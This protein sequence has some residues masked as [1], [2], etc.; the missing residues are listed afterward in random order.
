M[1]WV[2]TISV[3]TAIT[4]APVGSVCVGSS[5]QRLVFRRLPHWRSLHLL[6]VGVESRAFANGVQI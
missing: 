2:T 3:V 4:A 6:L 1:D 5:Q